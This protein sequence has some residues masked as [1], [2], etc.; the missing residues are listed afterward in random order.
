[1]K[2]T[3]FA[4]FALLLFAT[5]NAWSASTSQTDEII[6]QLLDV[7]N[8]R[9]LLDGVKAQLDAKIEND[10]QSLQKQAL[11]P[12]GQA[13][14]DRANVRMRSAVNEFLNWDALLPMYMRMYRETFSSE[15]LQGLLNFY[16]SKAGQAVIKKMPVLIHSLLDETQHSMKPALDKMT[17]IEQETLLELKALPAH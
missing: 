1:M 17:R 10:R 16:K 5:T 4:T 7:T 12:Q 2:L 3:V 8:S 6:R 11:T 15:E 13:I 9:Q 14:L